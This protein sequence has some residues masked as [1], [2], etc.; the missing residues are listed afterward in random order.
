MAETPSIVEA[1]RKRKRVEVDVPDTGARSL[2][3]EDRSASDYSVST[4]SKDVLEISEA[5]PDAKFIK[6]SNTSDEKV[7]Q[8]CNQHS[9]H[10]FHLMKI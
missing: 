2:V 4:V 5:N 1:A 8:S 7:C 3:R 6:I 9:C 10:S